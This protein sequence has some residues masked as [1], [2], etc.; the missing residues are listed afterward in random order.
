[1]NS[2]KIFSSLL[3]LLALGAT[4]AAGAETWRSSLYPADWKP[5][6]A[7]PEGRFLHDF[8]YAGYH[9]GERPLPRR[10]HHVIDVTAPPYGADGSGVRDAT[11]AIQSALDAAAEA[12]GGVVFMPAG[13]YRVA[14]AGNATFALQLSG[15]NVV[16]RGAGADKTFLF[17]DSLAMRNK[18]VI[19]V[20]P[21]TPVWWETN[22]YPSV[23]ITADL[24]GPATA[25]PVEDTNAFTVGGLVL[26][27]SDITRHMIDRLGMNGVWT[28]GQKYPAGILYCRRVTAIDS[29]AGTITVDVPLRGM[30]SMADGARVTVPGNGRLLSESGL[31]DF[32]IG[33]RQHP[34]GR[35][36]VDFEQKL[37]EGT[38]GYALQR[39]TA[40]TLD[41]TENCWVLR[42]NSYA[43]PG[44]D[45]DIHVQSHGIRLFRS[46]HVTVEDCK[47]RFPQYRGEGGNGYMFTLYGND[48]LIKNCEAEGGR[49]NFSFGEM[50]ANGNVI[51]N[52]HSKNSRLP[53]DFHMFLSLANLVDGAVCDGD[54]LQAVPR[55]QSKHGETTTQ[56]VFWNTEGLR[57]QNDFVYRDIPNKGARVIVQS[58]QW[59]DGYV[60]GTRGPA[61]EVETTD[62]SEGIGRGEG[63]QP[64][65]LYED[66]LKRRLARAPARK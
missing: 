56:S 43:P 10:T 11:A 35:V 64:R 29:V 19:L 53:S 24:P 41:S 66:Q 38:A 45:P 37:T 46:R 7:D 23:K 36:D 31:E 14:P 47:W 1:M 5:G 16:L 28:A 51:L 9:A 33:M 13:T 6:Y 65:S 55:N 18:R 60:I 57:Y 12:G 52:F 44:N 62:F 4:A 59:G 34:G 20:T 30:L 27:R 42:V 40:V 15:D 22:S 3:L 49:H 2:E 17:N 48:C 26:V 58:K 54:C 39:A 21:K 32:S 8:S 50:S 61:S 25:I 63:L